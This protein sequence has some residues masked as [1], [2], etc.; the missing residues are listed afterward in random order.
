M[1][2]SRILTGLVGAVLVGIFAS[3]M[4][5]CTLDI[6]G[7][8][9]KPPD[10]TKGGPCT[11]DSNCQDKLPCSPGVCAP[12]EK[13]CLYTL[14]DGVDAPASAQVPSDC[15]KIICTAGMPE[16]VDEPLDVINDNNSCT[17]DSC[18]GGVPS[19]EVLADGTT[20]D[21]GVKNGIC[22]AG[23][24]DIA[25]TTTSECDDE[26]PCSEDICNTGIGKCE[27][28]Y[29]DGVLTPGATQIPSDCKV[30][31]CSN[32][33]DGDVNDDA[34]VI[35][36]GNPCT[37]DICT[38]G[39][40]S[41]PPFA[42]KTSCMLPAPEE[43][44]V[45]DGNGTCVECVDKDDCTKI[46]ESECEKRSCVNNKCV[47]AYEPQTTLASPVL[48]AGNDCKKVVCSGMANPL[49]VTV[50]DNADLPNDANPCTI[51]TCENG[52][53]KFTD[54]AQGTNC[55]NNQVCNATG[56]CVGC[57]AP[58]DCMGTDDFCKTR[59]C[60]NNICGFSYTA[61]GTD[62]PTGQMTGDCKVLECDG[63][64]NVKTSVLQSDVPVDGNAC[65]QD[66]CNA[67][68]TPSN[69]AT[70]ANSPCSV[71]VNDACDGMGVCKK[72]LGKT[73]G[74]GTECVS[75]R[76]VDGVC[77]NSACTTL[78]EACNVTGSLGTCIA[79]PKGQ[80]DGTCT[81]TT[82]SCNASNDCDDEIGVACSANSA[83]LSNFCVDGVCCDAQCS[84][85]CKACSMAKTGMAS[86]TCS[87]VTTAT[88]PDNECTDQM[89]ST[90]GNNG[91]CDGSG[92]CQ[93]YMSG[94]VC[95]AQSCT[96]S[97]LSNA[98]TCNGNGTCTDN[99]TA[100]CAP[101]T[102]GGTACKTMCTVDGDCSS[103]NYCSGNAC[104]PKKPNGQTCTMGMG[105]QCTSGN[106]VDGVCCNTSCNADCKSCDLTG[107]V[108]TCSNVLVGVDDGACMGAN[109]CDGNGGCKLKNGE[110][111]TMLNGSQCASNFC[112][113]GFC[114]NSSC[115]MDCKSCDVA[116]SE[117]TC[118][119]ELVLNDDG[120][121]M[122]NNTCDGN[123]N[124]K[125]DNGQ[126]CTMNSQCAT[127]D[128]KNGQNVCQTP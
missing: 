93:K 77:C 125:L 57:N 30:R 108:G 95:A 61:N 80:D 91:L 8:A 2:R 29:L 71:G 73:C 111:C 94:T 114:C 44:N 16:K 117:G 51:D 24:C 6:E 122:G 76:C 67:M 36:D 66:V 103:G 88:D 84:G 56:D 105:N 96:G 27:F 19:N 11:D 90:C 62:L 12:E 69:P 99:G 121:C 89:A 58:T 25:C 35:V 28:T 110:T 14:L 82:Q 40:P 7:T 72:S 63:M 86:G 116:G 15:K 115:N 55:G 20:C 26:N 23:K 54:Q 18:T 10:V 123:G 104:V 109:T 38:A 39:V 92:A 52:T 43:T 3:Q 47:I 97:T 101:Y 59:T 127:N 33:V 13:V 45:C 68:G 22:T 4:A 79:V 34:D 119:N 100:N 118:S 83:C 65:T 50:S 42:P 106:C 124:C 98:D 128:C 48:Q 1:L 74:M 102:C 78:C 113:D 17:T 5:S 31:F 112:V 41:N 53:P 75:T 85:T 46:V 81:G 49:T 21:V 70:A 120:A 87:N 37:D 32:G 60:T 126:S 64:G 9:Q 107:L